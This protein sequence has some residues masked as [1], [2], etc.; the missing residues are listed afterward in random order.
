MDSNTHSTQPPSQK[1]EPDWL[2][3]LAMVADQLAAQDLN[4]LPDAALAAQ[5][6]EFRRLLDRLEGQWL[7]SSRP[8]TA[9]VPPVLKPTSRWGR[10]PPG[11]GV[12]CA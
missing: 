3:A 7:T 12:G 11:C 2:A 1:P 5:V 9:E 10:P 4:Q 8:L 6:L